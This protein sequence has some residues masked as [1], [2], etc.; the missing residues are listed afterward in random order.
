MTWGLPVLRF[1]MVFTAHMEANF[2]LPG[3]TAKISEGEI[4][5][6]LLKLGGDEP[7]MK[8]TIAVDLEYLKSRIDVGPEKTPW[9]QAT[10]AVGPAFDFT[11]TPGFLG[12]PN[13]DWESSVIKAPF[14]FGGAW[15]RKAGMKS[16][17]GLRILITK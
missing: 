1:E 3:F 6:D 13:G 8:S 12:G 7:M 16:Y 14:G 10:F 5:I 11:M 2:T 4:T 15:V 17:R 9:V